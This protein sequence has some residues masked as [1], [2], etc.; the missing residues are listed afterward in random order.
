LNGRTARMKRIVKTHSR[1]TGEA[2]TCPVII[3]AC[4]ENQLSYEYRY[5]AQS[6]GAFTFS[7][8]ETLRANRRRNRNPT[9]PQLQEGIKT[10]LKN[11]KYDQ[12]TNLVG[13]AEILRQQV[14]WTR[15]EARVKP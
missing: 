9:F 5:G 1:G 7:L 2:M 11:L 12:T 4:Q 6:Y 8:A 15:K 13:A 3:E 14:P 10:K